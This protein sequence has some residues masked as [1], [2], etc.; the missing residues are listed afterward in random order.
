MVCTD[1]SLPVLGMRGRVWG[2]HESLTHQSGR[3]VVDSRRSASSAAGRVS[4]ASSAVICG[5]SCAR[6]GAGSVALACGAR[7][8]GYFKYDACAC[9]SRAAGRFEFGMWF[10]STT[11]RLA[12]EKFECPR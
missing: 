10:A 7:P 11:A 8:A 3:C 12:V 2:R 6:V 4:A 9:G 5:A 1:H